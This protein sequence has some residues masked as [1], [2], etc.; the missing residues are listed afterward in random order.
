MSGKYDHSNSVPYSGLLEAM[1]N[2]CDD[3]LLENKVVFANYR[4]K[5]Q[6]AVGEEGQIL[7]QVISN[8]QYIIGGQPKQLVD[9]NQ[10]TKHRFNFVFVNFMKA[11]C[12]VGLPLII[13]LEDLQA[14]DL[15]SLDL[16]C[17]VVKDDSIKN[18]MLVGTYCESEISHKPPF[19]QLLNKIKQLNTNVINIKLTN[20]DHESTNDIIAQFL[21][22]SPFET[23]A[24]TAWVFDKTS[25][26]PHFIT[27]M[28]KS[29]VEQKLIFYCSNESK[30]R[31]DKSIYKKE[32]IADS[33]LEILS[34]KI[35]RFDLYKAQ[36][37]MIA[38]CL[39]RSFSISIL[40]IIINNDEGVTDAISSGM[41]TQCEG[42]DM[43]NFVHD[44]A[45]NA[46]YSLI[47]QENSKEIFFHV[48]KKLWALLSKA[49]LNKNLFTIC[50]LLYESISIV[51]DRQDRLKIA[52]LFNDA[53]E[54]ALASTLVQKA[55]S[56][57]DAGIKLL[58]SDRWQYYDLSLKLHNSCAKCALYLDDGEKLHSLK[59]EVFN[60][61][62][63]VIDEV[64]LCETQIKFYNQNLRREEA[65]NAAISIVNRMGETIHLNSLSGKMVMEECHKA[66]C[67]IDG[68]SNEEVL[69]AMKP[70]NS[71]DTK[72][73]SVMKIFNAI[74][75]SSFVYNVHLYRYIASEYFVIH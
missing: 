40:K 71:N 60:N 67:L 8:L 73:L 43:Y 48:A 5:I 56:Y 26:N 34:N 16:L 44:Q 65:I 32:G 2:F 23:Y 27:E 59:N 3:L 17:S 62:N 66:K 24:L 41:I 54:R 22:T 19:T 61:A 1:K 68:R 70:M 13:V 53:G 12:S 15:D 31:C 33:V 50:H 49:E 74:I 75:S 58:G 25:G 14:L 46:A 51:T 29:L 69:W 28:L 64:Q 55:F 7:T 37:L 4:S 72:Q 36:T 57:F 39:G 63:S 45:K 38:S 6:D 9:F 52:S 42:S 11:L 18:L 21:N 30:W 47:P 20:L 10:N 35:K